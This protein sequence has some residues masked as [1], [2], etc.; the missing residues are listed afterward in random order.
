MWSVG[1]VGQKFYLPETQR[2][3]M[4]FTQIQTQIA[5]RHIFLAYMNEFIG[6]VKK[7]MLISSTSKLKIK[8]KVQN[9]LLKW[10]QKFKSLDISET[11]R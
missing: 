11:S 3:P 8:L 4:P 6:R 5:Q 2:P 7:V 1:Q 10:L 9:T